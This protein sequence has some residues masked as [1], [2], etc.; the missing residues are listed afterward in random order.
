MKRGGHGL[1]PRQAAVRR[2]TRMCL[3]DMQAMRCSWQWLR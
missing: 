1:I 3:R 2:L